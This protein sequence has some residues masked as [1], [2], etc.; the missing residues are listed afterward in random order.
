MEVAVPTNTVVR[1]RIDERIKNEAAAVLEAMGLSV[2][3]AFRML[4]VRIAAEKALPFEPLTPNQETIDVIKAARRG[5]LVMAGPPD[6]LIVSLN[7]DC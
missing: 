1:A 3:D 5:E 7:E 2:S 4:L 6:A